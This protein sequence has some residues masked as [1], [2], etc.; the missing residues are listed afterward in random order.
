LI[1]GVRAK[2]R[3]VKQSLGISL[4]PQSKRPRTKDDDDEEEGERGESRSSEIVVVVL[5]IGC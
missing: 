5:V 4:V 2:R 1:E 3:E